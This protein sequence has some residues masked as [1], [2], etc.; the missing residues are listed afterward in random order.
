MKRF[1]RLF[2]APCFLALASSAFAGTIVAT[3]DDLPGH[4]Q[5]IPAVYAGINWGAVTWAYSDEFSGQYMP[6]S[7][8]KA[9]YP[10]TPPFVADAEFSF[11]DGD[12]IFVGAW[13][14]GLYGA[15]VQFG[16]YD[17]SA[18]VW[19]SL[20]LTTTLQP[21]F[22]SSGYSGPVDRVVIRTSN[23]AFWVIDDVTYSS[24]PEPSTY[25][26]LGS[27][28]LGLLAIRRKLGS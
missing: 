21:Q 28:L 12:Q 19:T 23:V 5:P 10:I 11:A 8:T 26:L 20:E 7:G 14:S 22:L 3:F 4:N 18:L 9:A 25:A 27:G 16:L 24:I 13:F 2:L 6:Y 17:D 15:T 1:S